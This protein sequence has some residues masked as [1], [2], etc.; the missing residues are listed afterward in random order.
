MANPAIVSC[1]KNT[2]TKVATNVTAGQVKVQDQSALYFETY[3]LTG[4]SA[5][6]GITELSGLHGKTITIAASAAIDVYIYCQRNDGLVR[7]DV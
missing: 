3:R 1:P 6:T 4:N 7:V 2:W 5:P